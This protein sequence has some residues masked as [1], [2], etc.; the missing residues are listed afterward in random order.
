MA[1]KITRRGHKRTSDQPKQIS[2]RRARFDYQLGDTLSVGI[3]LN[4]RETKALRL[5]HGQL[6]GAYVNVKKGELWL[7]NAAIHGTSGIPISED[8]QTRD[9][10]L[11]A[12]RREID[13]LIAAKQN[14]LTI[15]PLEI[16]TRGRYIKVKISTAKGKKNWDK[17]Q[18]LKKREQDRQARAASKIR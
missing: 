12:K 9:R 3:A 14:G 10:K 1:K 5:G 6:H 2:N 8:E 11:L 7:T 13:K 15:V 18:T 17:R 4:G 16:L